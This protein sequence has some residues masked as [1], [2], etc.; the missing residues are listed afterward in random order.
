[1]S[2]FGF[3]GEEYGEIECSYSHEHSLLEESN[4][5]EKYLNMNYVKFISTNKK[6]L[7]HAQLLGNNRKIKLVMKVCLKELHQYEFKHSVQ[8]LFGEAGIKNLSFGFDNYYEIIMGFFEKANIND[9]R[10]NGKVNVS[11]DIRS[12]PAPVV[13]IIDNFVRSNFGVYTHILNKASRA[14]VPET[15]VKADIVESRVVLKE[16]EEEEVVKSVQTFQLIVPE[17]GDEWY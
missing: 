10:M 13:R 8:A 6:Q 4:R 5:I 7:E 12:V 14:V 11:N 17:C 9:I 1:M 16:E 15:K 3:D 2:D